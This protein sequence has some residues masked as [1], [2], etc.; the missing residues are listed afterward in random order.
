MI[1]ICICDD[2][3]TLRKELKNMLNQYLGEQNLEIFEYGNISELL[4]TTR[5]YDVLFLDIRFDGKDAGVEAAK[6]LRKNGSEAIIIF[7]TSLSGYATNGYEAEAFRY[8]IKPVEPGVLT[9]TMDAVI[10]KLNADTFRLSVVSRSGTVVIEASDI[11]HIESLTRRRFINTKSEKIETWETMAD[12]YEKLPKGQFVYI[13]KGYVSNLDFIKQVKN[14]V[15]TL[16]NDEHIPLGRNYK[17]DF[18]MSFNRYV[19]GGK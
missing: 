11:S 5:S 19:G 15:V 9:E 2:E 13:Q 7:L 6:R 12:L 14:N 18:F 1:S 17:K 3:V 16:K 8:L 10:K 4:E